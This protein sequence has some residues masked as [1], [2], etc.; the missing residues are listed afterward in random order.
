MDAGLLVALAIIAI[1]LSP[2]PVS[3]LYTMACIQQYFLLQN[4]REALQNIREALQNIREA[5]Q[6]IRE[7]FQNIREALQN[8]REALQNIREALQNIREALQN[9]CFIPP[10]TTLR[11]LASSV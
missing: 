6:N 8:I 7:A 4:I 3:D 5:F 2:L 11:A 1:T 10:Q 9:H